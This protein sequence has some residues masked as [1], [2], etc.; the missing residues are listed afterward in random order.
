MRFNDGR[1]DAAGRLWVGTMVMDMSLASSQGGL[2]CL[3]ERGLTGP[4][5]SELITPNGLGFSPD[6][7][8]ISV[9]F[10]PQVQQILGLR[11]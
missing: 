6:H 1:C 3:D 4:Y 7:K 10:P 5:V 11:L 9:R 2:Y 8:T